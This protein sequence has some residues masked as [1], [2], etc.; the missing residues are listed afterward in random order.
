MVILHNSETTKSKMVVLV[1][2][3][4]GDTIVVILHNGENV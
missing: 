1:I 2:L 3:H 4:N